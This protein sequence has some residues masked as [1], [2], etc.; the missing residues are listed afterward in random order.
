MRKKVTIKKR[1]V[2]EIEGVSGH[3]VFPNTKQKATR[4]FKPSVATQNLHRASDSKISSLSKKYLSSVTRTSSRA[5]LQSFY[6]S[7]ISG[8]EYRHMTFFLLSKASL[9]VYS[10]FIRYF[11]SLKIFLLLSRPIYFPLTLLKSKTL[12]HITSAGTYIRRR[13]NRKTSTMNLPKLLSP[14]QSP[15]RPNSSRCLLYTSPSPRDS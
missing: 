10:N 8:L 9:P 14:I 2:L 12:I 13:R 5:S 7:A 11:T 3:R 1:R 4:G 6:E 15:T